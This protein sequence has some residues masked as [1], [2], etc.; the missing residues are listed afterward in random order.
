MTW[1]FFS[2]AATFTNKVLIKEYHLSAGM[3][4]LCHLFV[5]VVMDCT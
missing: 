1:Y 5:S 2:T 3:L 4:T